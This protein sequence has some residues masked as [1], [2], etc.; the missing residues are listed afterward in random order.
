MAKIVVVD[1]D[2]ANA[3]VMEVSLSEYEVQIFLLREDAEAFLATCEPGQVDLVI[4]DGNIKEENDG[5]TVIVPAAQ[6]AGI[7][8]ALLSGKKES[9]EK[10]RELGVPVMEKPFSIVKLLSWIEQLLAE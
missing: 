9:V 5:I 6:L 7:K 2:S 3:R 1:D 4:T 10:A 8:V